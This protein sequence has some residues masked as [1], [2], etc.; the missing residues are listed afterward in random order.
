MSEEPFREVIEPRTADVGGLPINRALPHRGLRGIGPWVFF[1][2]M[3]P[4]D[5]LPG[6]RM[7][8]IPHPHINLATV[9]YLFE[10]RITHRDSLGTVQDIEPGAIN[11]MIAGRGIAHS[12]RTPPDLRRTGYRAHGL[13]LWM[14]LPEEAE[15][16]KPSFHHY[17]AEEIPSTEIGDIP[18][19]V[20][21]GRA[22]GLE[23]PVKTLSPTLYI[24]ARWP[25]GGRLTL[26][27]EAA[28]R[29]LYVVNGPVSVDGRDLAAGRFAV[30][31]P[32][33]REVVAD[34]GALVV[35]IGGE[36]PGDRYIWWNFVSSRGDRI[37]QAKADWR[38]GRFA[39]VIDDTGE[40][41]PLP[42]RD[43]HARMLG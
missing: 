24:E 18:V 23:S 31:T 27:E 32:E 37:E 38:E 9:T 22:W 34:T 5:I 25:A 4:A 39:G 35:L 29:G 28:E 17:P 19:R 26:P 3:G 14:A 13:Q 2:H 1:D 10:G 30:L 8:V 40:R 6:G 12:E 43:S 11:L 21:M 16:D 41:A 36:S 42:E 7:D 15:E 33:A 20:M